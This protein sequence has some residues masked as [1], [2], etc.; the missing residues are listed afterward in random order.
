MSILVPAALAFS[1]IIPIILLLYFMRPKRQEKVVGSTLLWQQAMQDLQASRPWQRLRITPLLL[2]QLLA[3]IVIILILVRPAI[4]MSSPVSGNTIV[5]L[6]ASASMQAT[7]VAP[8]RFD[9]AKDTIS[10]FIDALG[11]NDHLSLISMARTPQVLI[12]NSQDKAQLTNALQH[13]RVTNQDADLE[14]ALSLASSLAAGQ[15]NAQVLVVGDGHVMNNNQTLD[16]PFPV[17]YMSIGGDAPNMA[18]MALSS[19]SLQGKLI[20]FAQVSNYSHDQRSVPVELYADGRLFSVKTVTL[21]AGA[22]GAIEWG[23]LPARTNLLHARLL[24]QDAMTTDHEAWSLVGSSIHGRVLLVTKGNMYLQT[25]LRLQSNVT[26]YTIDP[27]KYSNSIGTYDL[28]I[29]DGY[30]PPSEP[31]G[32]ILYVNPPARNYSFGSSGPAVGVSHISTGNDPQNLLSSIDLSSIHTMRSTHQLKPALW[33][34]PIISTP[35]TPLLLA[36]ENNN[37]RVAVF[38]F[39]LHE[40]DLPLQPSFPILIYNLVNWFLPSPVAGNGQVTPG[41]PVS[42][43]TWPGA[44]QVTVTGPDQQTITV[45]PPFPATPY[46]RTNPVGIYQ[47]NQRVHGHTLSGIFTVN[48]FNPNQSQLAPAKNIPVT[49]STNITNNKNTISR[50]LREIWP[51]IAA[52]LLLILCAEWWL[53]SRNYQPQQSNNQTAHKT[54]RTTIRGKT[55]QRSARYPWLASMQDQVLAS[56]NRTQRKTKKFSKRLRTTLKKTSKGE[57]RVNI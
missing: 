30:A 40:T 47:V 12:A 7:D 32:N 8:S 19:R 25:A 44:D 34:Q 39:D 50:Q 3:A 43:Q 1:A 51:W 28:T 6:Q 23:P 38:G 26:L 52:I 45:G 2:L 11:P 9:K 57:R 20:A 49:H 31:V 5:I 37:R 14:Q 24:S 41:T 33:A 16:S 48:L 53:F 54:P 4:F 27:S 10:G 22:S 15:E 21:N 55:N 29:F 46:A 56:W 13:A 36:G 35:T 18:L 42:I 17:Q